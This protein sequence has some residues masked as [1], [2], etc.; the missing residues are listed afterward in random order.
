MGEI[1]SLAELVL[2]D[3]PTPASTVI[4]ASPIEKV[5]VLVRDADAICEF[6]IN[7]AWTD[8]LRL[9]RGIAV[10]RAGLA[11]LYRTRGSARGIRLKNAVTGSPAT[12]VIFDLY[13]E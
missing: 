12:L 13:T 10:S 2:P 4:T 5:D 3:L 9:S 1:R 11:D 8:P 7:N 6:L